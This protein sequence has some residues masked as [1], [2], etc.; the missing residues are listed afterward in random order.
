MAVCQ[1]HHM[2]IIPDSR[3]VR[4]IVVV[5]EYAHL[6]QLTHSHLSDV[7]RQVVGDAGRVFSDHA[8]L[9]GAHRIKIT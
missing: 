3:S 2:D 6:F 7:G 9:M 8:A 1:I 5:S 4:R